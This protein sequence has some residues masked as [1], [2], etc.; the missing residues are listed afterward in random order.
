M[1]RFKT[2]VSQYTPPGT[3][4]GKGKGGK[5]KKRGADGNPK[6]R[7]GDANTGGSHRGGGGW[8]ECPKCGRKHP[9]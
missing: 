3:G 6:E 8:K 1:E 5:G 9:G 7:E 2:F 4:V